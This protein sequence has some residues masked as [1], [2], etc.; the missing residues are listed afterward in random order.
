MR[1]STGVNG[2]NLAAGIVPPA[3]GCVLHCVLHLRN[4]VGQITNLNGILF[5]E[6]TN[7]DNCDFVK[8]KDLRFTG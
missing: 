5:S 4:N 8:G 2:G 6:R 7:Y 1:P 3:V